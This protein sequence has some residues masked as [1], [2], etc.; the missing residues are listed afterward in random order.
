LGFDLDRTIRALKPEKRT[1][2]LAYRSAA[3]LVA[4]SDLA[5]KRPILPDATV[6]VHAG[7][8]RLPVGIAG[9]LRQW[10]L[11]H[12]SV[13]LGEIAHGIG[14]LDPAHTMTPGRRGYLEGVLRQVPQHRIVSPDDDVHVAAGIVTGVLARLLGLPKGGHRLKV[15]DVLILLT[16]RKFGA[17]LVTANVGDLDVAQQLR[18]DADVIYYAV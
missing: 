4:A 18:P 5:T 1:A 2:P 7:Q 12:C 10:P 16:A 8:G 3:G 14:R 6:Y 13:A 9:M 11:L 15:N 17:A